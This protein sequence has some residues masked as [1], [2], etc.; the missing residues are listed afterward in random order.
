MVK[1]YNRDNIFSVNKIKNSSLIELDDIC[2]YHSKLGT[3]P[4]NDNYFITTTDNKHFRLTQDNLN[5]LI[6]T[7]TFDQGYII[8][9]LSWQEYKR[10]SLLLPSGTLDAKPLSYG[11]IVEPILSYRMEPKKMIYL[12]MKHIV[13]YSTMTYK[14][15]KKDQHI[16][17]SLDRDMYKKIVTE[18]IINSAFI[19][20]KN[21]KKMAD[22]L[23]SELN[24]NNITQRHP[25]NDRYG[26]PFYLDEYRKTKLFLKLIPIDNLQNIIPSTNINDARIVIKS[27]DQFFETKY[28]SIRNGT[29]A[30]G[31]ILRGNLLKNIEILDI[32]DFVANFN[33]S[34]RNTKY[35]E[36]KEIDFTVPSSYQCYVIAYEV[37]QNGKVVGR[38]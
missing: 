4:S 38:K 5:V 28:T 13:E 12:G 7:A 29:L 1:L 18:N 37:H 27:G 21:D 15:V 23:S 25:W 22:E 32:D 26:R 11:D 10:K 3:D 14:K 9:P 34:T 19:I 8:G 31:T 30:V 6:K 24:T 36:S 17:I 35:I 16:F 33:Y 20:L 2:Y